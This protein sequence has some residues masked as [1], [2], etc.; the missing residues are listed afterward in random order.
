MSIEVGKK[1]GFKNYEH[2]SDPWNGDVVTVI[3]AQDEFGWWEIENSEGDL[4]LAY[5]EELTEVPSE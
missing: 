3:R 1:Y 4:G 2:D 5:T